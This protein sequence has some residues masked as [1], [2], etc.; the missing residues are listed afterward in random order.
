[1]LVYSLRKISISKIEGEMGISKLH[2]YAC[3]AIGNVC[4]HG[5]GGIRC[6]KCKIMVKF[7][8][9]VHMELCV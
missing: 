2:N 4:S 7:V 5:G 3:N 1:M 8:Y 9:T 6:I